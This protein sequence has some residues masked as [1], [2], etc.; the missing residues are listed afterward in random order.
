MVILLRLK[1]LDS[2]P[3]TSNPN[4]PTGVQSQNS[5]KWLSCSGAV[6]AGVAVCEAN[7]DHVLN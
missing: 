2:S 1:I 3:M 5:W 7:M 6:C 4:P